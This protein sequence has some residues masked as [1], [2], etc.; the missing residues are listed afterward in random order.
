MKPRATD[1]EQTSILCEQRTDTVRKSLAARIYNL[2]DA[3]H[4]KGHADKT[5]EPHCIALMNVSTD[6]KHT[7]IDQFLDTMKREFL[8]TIS[9]APLLPG[10]SSSQVK[11][12]WQQHVKKIGGA[13]N[14][15]IH[16]IDDTVDFKTLM[17]WA[18]CPKLDQCAKKKH[19]LCMQVS[20]EVLQ[21]ILNSDYKDNIQAKE[22]MNFMKTI[23]PHWISS[24]ALRHH[25]P[26]GQ[27]VLTSMPLHS[28][29]RNLNVDNSDKTTS[30]SANTSEMG[31]EALP[32]A[33]SATE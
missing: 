32:V 7:S 11:Q 16:D 12:T 20:T 30:Q 22:V 31:K 18:K 14:P 3:I 28:A 27:V 19:L 26:R 4:N 24:L 6:Y 5:L 17:A 9:A 8:F 33:T 2:V 1:V 25:S 10:I 23:Q 29:C 15:T 21:S 13:N